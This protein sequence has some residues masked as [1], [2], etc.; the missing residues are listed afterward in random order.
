[1][2]SRLR[3]IA[4]VQIGYQPRGQVTPGANGSHWLIQ[5]RDLEFGGGKV[6][7]SAD[8]ALWT[9]RNEQLDRI[10]P[11]GDALA[12]CVGVGDVLFLSRGLYPIAIPLSRDLLGDRADAGDKLIAAYTFYIVRPKA[13]VLPEF[14]AWFINQAPSQA[15]L[16]MHL[17][18]SAAKLLPK[19]ALDEMT[20]I[21]PPVSLQNRIV[22]IDHLR[23]HEDSL[24][25]RL[26]SAR[27]R[28]VQAACLAAIES[29]SAKDCNH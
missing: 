25:A 11:K 8:P 7:G 6:D 16:Q 10:T 27:R 5:G 17:R 9:I 28:L 2:E 22:E 12:Y 24:M 19:S 26:A 18:G 3:D 29:K 23:A 13:D 21:V 15:Y 14:L 1:M 4:E 20:V